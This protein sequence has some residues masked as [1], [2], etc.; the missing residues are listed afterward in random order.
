M[1]SAAFVLG[2]L[3]QTASPPNPELRTLSFIAVDPKG[4]PEDGLQPEEVAVLED[5]VA[6]IVSKVEP[7][8]RPLTVALLADTSESIGTSFRLDVIDGLSRLLRGLPQGTQFSVWVTGDRPRK[9]MD[10]GE[11]VPA[12]LE[13]LKKVF[14]QGGNTLLDAIPEAS[15][16]LKKQEGA[17]SAVVI[18][19]G[20]GQDFSNRDQYRAVEDSLRNA[21]WFMAVEFETGPTEFETR[22]RYD[23]TL[24][25]LT[26]KTGG[27]YERLLSPTGAGDALGRVLAALRSTY[28]VSYASAGGNPKKLAVVVAR[29]GVRVL[30]PADGKGAP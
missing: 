24:G 20:I 7:D 12:A 26:A 23:Y 15:R 22:A 13:A 25:S 3:L 9:V 11:D 17:R 14:P 10:F 30:L 16:D 18:V 2:L 19:T 29:P 8:T 6:R 5:G 4:H 1:K 21:T 27:V 28:R